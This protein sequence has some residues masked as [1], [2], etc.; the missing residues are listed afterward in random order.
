MIIRNARQVS[1]FVV[2]GDLPINTQF[3]LWNLWE[4]LFVIYNYNNEKDVESIQR[5]VLFHEETILLLPVQRHGQN[6]REVPCP[7]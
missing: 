2:G 7:I 6:A 5:E 3:H 1:E 4:I